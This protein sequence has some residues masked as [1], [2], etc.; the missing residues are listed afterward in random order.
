MIFYDIY[1]YLLGIILLP[2]II[3][4]IWAQ[5]KVT[6]NFN[7]YNNIPSSRDIPA[8][9]LARKLLDGAG[10]KDVKI[11]SCKGSL[12]DHFN[13]KSNTVAL[14]ETVY[15]STSVASL[16]VMAHELGHVL[17]YKDKY[18][19][20]RVKSF[21]V[22]FINF[23]NV[24]MWPLVI[25]GVIIEALTYTSIGG[26]FIIVGI[27]IF[28]LSTLLSLI[29]LPIELNASKRAY[30]LLVKTEILTEE[31][32]EGVKKVL[33]SAALTYLAGLVTS[34]LS[35]L[36]FVLYILTITKKD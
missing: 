32:G 26:I 6:S 1:Y 24:F 15:N 2:G 16:G 20:I 29:T 3:M 36:R 23:I 14:S 22:P 35:L 7:K 13:P 27:C 9:Q 33:N 34:I 12:T 31:E 25:V 30:T 21:L 28:G 11:T 19:W 17:Q 4:S 18:F 5:A 10:L 8:N